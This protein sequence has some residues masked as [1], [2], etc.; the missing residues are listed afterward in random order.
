MTVYSRELVKGKRET[1]DTRHFAATRSV[2]RSEASPL[3]SGGC[4]LPF[5][6]P[7]DLIPSSAR[8][9]A[10][11]HPR[12]PFRSPVSLTE[13]A[14]A[15]PHPTCLSSKRASAT[16]SRVESRYIS[17]HP[18]SR[19][20]FPSPRLPPRAATL[21]AQPRLSILH[22]LRVPSQSNSSHPER[23]TVPELTPAHSFADISRRWTGNYWPGSCFS[24]LPAITLVVPVG[25]SI[26]SS[27]PVKSLRI[28][29]LS[30]SS[31]FCLLVA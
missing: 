22:P 6:R 31:L 17:P 28:L 23:P 13:C 24:L 20:R 27:A 26:S 8:S 14:I 2:K 9:L 5:C 12:P 4:W 10:P 19:N 15:L 25:T 1:R 30:R 18:S 7:P 3:T 21:R 29:S 16:P 11:H